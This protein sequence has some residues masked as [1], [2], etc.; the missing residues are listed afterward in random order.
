MADISKITTIDG[1][2]YNLKDSVARREPIE[3]RTYTDVIAT[4]NENRYAGFFYMKLRA[5]SYTDMWR[6]IVRVRA[7]V[8]GNA[9]NA[10]YYETD[11]TMELWGYANTYDG[12]Y[13]KNLIKST[14][15][16]PIYYHSIFFVSQTGYSNDCG[17]W[18]G[19]NLL[20][21]TNNTNTSY[22][23]KIIVD[24]LDYENCIVEF[25]DTLI[26]PDN[27]PNRSAHT[28]WYSSSNTSFTNLDACS[29]GVK[30][31]GDANSTSI[32]AL[33]RSSGNFVAASALYRYQMLFH[34]DEDTLTP[35][36]NDNNA[37]NSTTKTMLTSVEFDPFMPIYYYATTTNVAA[38][39][40]ISAGALFWHYAGVDL[41][42][43][44]NCGT[45]LTA[46]KPFYLV[47][48]PTSGGKCKIASTTPWTQ[49]LP[50]TNDGNWYILLGRTYSTYQMTIYEDHPI[51]KYDGTSV[52]RIS[53]FQDNVVAITNAEI[54][55]ITG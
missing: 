46:N 33:Y 55:A 1:T 34:T 35:L 21:A 12:Y 17:N 24:L 28:G 39:G 4:A 8:P 31:S 43:T 45:T 40:A 3:S 37:Y 38:A 54:D 41:R 22:K 30:M 32:H 27:I 51:Y 9:S 14:S 11:S 44:F 29:N 48:T 10:L 36:N 50:S 18:L 5:T 6:V 2:T 23:R 47:V 49:A 42:Y 52:V 16:R 7:T 15:Y 53:P 13:N 20:Y 26:T 19:I 25:S